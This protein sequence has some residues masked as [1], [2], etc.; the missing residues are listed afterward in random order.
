MYQVIC[1]SLSG[2]KEMFTGKM[3]WLI[4]IQKL[5][6]L[7]IHI[8]I[9]KYFLRNAGLLIMNKHE[10]HLDSYFEM[11]NVYYLSCS[12]KQMMEIKYVLLQPSKAYNKHS[13]NSRSCMA[14]IYYIF[15]GATS[16]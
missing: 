16:L 15:Y 6:T 9:L 1:F 3:D 12:F 14:L 4:L 8:Y 7:K 2:Y 10:T 11:S 5:Q 13:I